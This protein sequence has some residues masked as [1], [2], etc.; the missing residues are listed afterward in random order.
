LYHPVGCLECRN[1][2]FQGRVGLYELLLL[3]P[4]IKKLI[5]SSTDIAQLREQA[6]REGMKPLRISGARK[7]AAGLTTIEEVLKVAPPGLN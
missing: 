6:A 5:T 3:S 7:V 4:E 2:G 1:S